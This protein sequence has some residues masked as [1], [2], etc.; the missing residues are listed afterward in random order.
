LPFESVTP[1]IFYE[2][3]D[4]NIRGA[5][6]TIQ[7]LLPLLG[8]RK[9][10]GAHDFSRCGSGLRNLQRVRGDQGSPVVARTDLVERARAAASV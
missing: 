8:E 4:I 9:L 5:Y 1:E 6:F 7:K 3:F 10:R 2:M